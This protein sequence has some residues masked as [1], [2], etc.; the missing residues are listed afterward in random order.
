MMM[1]MM[2]KKKKKKRKETMIIIM[3]IMV[4]D[5]DNDDDDDDDGGGGVL[6]VVKLVMRM[7]KGGGIWVLTRDIVKER[8]L[9]RLV[10]GRCGGA[11]HDLVGKQPS[12][13]NIVTH[14]HIQGA[15]ISAQIVPADR[16]ARTS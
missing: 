8:G 12:R 7:A 2:K 16:A 1:M 3:M 14:T 5:D 11:A 9:T 15:K 10:V 6:V 13:V 4:I